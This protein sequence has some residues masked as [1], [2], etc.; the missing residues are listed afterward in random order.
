MTGLSMFHVKNHWFKFCEA[1][2]EKKMMKIFDP[3]QIFRGGGSGSAFRSNMIATINFGPYTHQKL[4]GPSFELRFSKT[5][6]KNRQKNWVTFWGGGDFLET[7]QILKIFTP[8]LTLLTYSQ[9]PG[10]KSGLISPTVSEICCTVHLTPKRRKIFLTFLP[11]HVNFW[12]LKFYLCAGP[13]VP[14]LREKFFVPPSP[15]MGEI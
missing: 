15:L 12:G 6:V 4:S 10:A 5:F 2:S 9:Q 8:A 11:T 1:K 14:Y 7:N 13:V 3:A